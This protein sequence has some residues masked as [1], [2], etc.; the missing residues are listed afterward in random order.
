MKIILK[1]GDVM[2]LENGATAYA[3]ALAISE[4]LE[5][6]AVCAKVNGELVDL[7]RTLSDNDTLEIVTMKDKEGLNVYRHTC[8]HVLAQALK[9][10]YPT[11]KLSIGPVIENG[12]YYDVDFVTP[13]S[14]SDLSKVEAEMKQIIKGNFP[15]ERFT[16]PKEEAIALMQDY[17]EDYKVQ[18]IEDLPEGETISFYKQGNFTDLCR[19]PHLPSTGKIK[20][21]K[22][23][24]IAGAYWRG[25][26]HNKMLTRIYG[27]AFAKKDEM[28][29][30]F[31]MLEEAKKRDHLKV[32]KELKLFALMNEG[33][34]LPFFLPNGMVLKN[35]LIEYWR[36]I[37]TRDGYVEISTPIML[38]KTLWETSG[39]W[40]HYRNN[41]YTTKV[42]EEDF[43]IKPMNCPGSV[44]VYKNEP[45]SY[46]DLPIRMGELGLVHRHEK[47]GQL[48]GLFRVRSFTQDDA[49]IFMTR[50]QIKD[51]IKGIV[52]LINEVYTLFG[53]KYHVELSTRPENSMGSDE[54][55]NTATDAL[56]MALEDMGM[57][58]VVN[59]GD[60][61]FY[62]PKIDF[63]L[64][65]SI[66]RTWQCGT[67]QLDFQLPQRF[68]MEYVGEDGAKH[69]PIM[70]HRVVFGSI[71]RFIGIL[72][73]HFAGKFPVWL[74]PLQVKIL[75]ITD[76][77]EGYAKEVCAKMREAGIRVSVDDRNEKIGYKIREAQME[78]VPYM[79]V[80]G[81]KEA[82]SGQVAVR[83]RDK[84]D[85]GAIAV[86]E[87]ISTVLEDIADKKSF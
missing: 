74:S 81:E 86:D 32:G 27:T 47:S 14:A 40:A 67:I 75:P 56:R 29:A 8:A 37:H 49:H 15:I 12:F 19:G 28:D 39:H 23:T 60:G 26:E 63:H 59:E 71:E 9:T 22:L 73:E 53:F 11:C 44:L 52:R 45:H 62:G 69:Q 16:L 80:I 46:K 68:E 78:K 82:E 54:D 72:I 17:N 2:E 34:G 77:Q 18:L 7:S 83:R 41:M 38:N 30:Y 36:Q 1:N 58:Y 51:E 55:W 4:G 10:V 61:A 79:L 87:F 3:A 20:A 50:E 42:D 31:T 64:E 21:F 48:H 13:I 66:G 5:R 6:N 24:S 35:T 65:D 85:M 43:A 76:K 84:G 57:Q 70:V 33:K 25:D